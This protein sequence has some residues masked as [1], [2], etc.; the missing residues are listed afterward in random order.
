MTRILTSSSNSSFF[1]DKFGP[2]YPTLPLTS[3]NIHL[4]NESFHNNKNQEEEEKKM[5]QMSRVSR[6]SQS[7]ENFNQETR[8]IRRLVFCSSL[9]IVCLVL[10]QTLILITKLVAI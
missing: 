1:D 6:P 5:R 9:V 7:K 10:G 4:H 3:Q 2:N 8:R